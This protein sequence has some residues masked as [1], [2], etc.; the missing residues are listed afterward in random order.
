MLA[1]GG[2][3]LHT[4]R[5]APTGAVIFVV[6]ERWAQTTNSASVRPAVEMDRALDGA[7]IA[8]AG[9]RRPRRGQSFHEEQDDVAATS[10]SGPSPGLPAAPGDKTLPV[11]SRLLR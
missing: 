2:L 3:R 6:I 1:H 5:L 11:T 4:Y 7:P 8:G 9:R 10:A